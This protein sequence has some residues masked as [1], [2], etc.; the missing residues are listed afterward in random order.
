MLYDRESLRPAISLPSQEMRVQP[1][2]LAITLSTPAVSQSPVED[3]QM[4]V[5]SSGGL[6][7]PQFRAL[8]PE[9]TTKQ[10]L[11]LFRSQRKRSRGIRM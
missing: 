3:K 5:G 9:L 10:A 4:D 6:T 2:G 8:H 1:S 7:W 11:D